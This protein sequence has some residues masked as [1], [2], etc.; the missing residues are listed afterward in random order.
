MTQD[1]LKSLQ[2]GIDRV[3]QVLDGGSN[4]VERL[5]SLLRGASPDRLA[6]LDVIVRSF[7]SAEVH[8][9]KRSE[10]RGGRLVLLKSRWVEAYDDFRRWQEKQGALKGEKP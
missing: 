4:A 10:P 1:G 6:A 9:T 5:Q 8:A 2:Q 7:I 3:R